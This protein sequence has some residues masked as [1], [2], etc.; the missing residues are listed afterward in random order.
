MINTNSTHVY[1]TVYQKKCWPLNK[2]AVFMLL[3]HL[4]KS[5]LPVAHMGNNQLRKSPYRGAKSDR[6]AGG[7]IVRWGVFFK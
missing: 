5:Q 6:E 3:H 4:W 7:K 2:L 1:F